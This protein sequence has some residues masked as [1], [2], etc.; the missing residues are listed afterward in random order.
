MP[1]KQVAKTVGNG[2]S[3]VP[4]KRDGAGLTAQQFADELFEFEYCGECAGDIEDHMFVIGPM[5]GWFALC[6]SNGI[7]GGTEP[8]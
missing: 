2:F 8:V 5:G 4:P 6:D 7:D 1:K 3:P